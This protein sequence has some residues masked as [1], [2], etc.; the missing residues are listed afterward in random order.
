MKAWAGGVVVGARAAKQPRV[1]TAAYRLIWAWR[2]GCSKRYNVLVGYDIYKP[3]THGYVAESVL[4]YL[5]HKGLMLRT[6]CKEKLR[7]NRLS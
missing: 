1:V 4:F 7:S 6:F 5:P 2:D 3:F